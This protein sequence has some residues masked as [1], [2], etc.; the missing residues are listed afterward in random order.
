MLEVQ[1]AAG[2][3]RKQLQPI[4]AGLTPFQFGFTKVQKPGAV[5]LS[6]CGDRQT[7]DTP[8]MIYGSV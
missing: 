3:S 2:V 4:P 8:T 5:L 1:E 7:S 6:V